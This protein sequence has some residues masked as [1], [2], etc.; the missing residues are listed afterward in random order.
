V[1]DLFVFDDETHRPVRTGLRPAFAPLL[2][3]AGVQ[4]PPAPGEL[5]IDGKGRRAF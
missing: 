5:E 2:E 1:Q 3:R 4:Y